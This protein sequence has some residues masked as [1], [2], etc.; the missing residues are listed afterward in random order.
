L[1]VE[2][3]KL[4]AAGAVRGRGEMPDRSAKSFSGPFQPIP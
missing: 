3:Q 4:R 1:R 2:K